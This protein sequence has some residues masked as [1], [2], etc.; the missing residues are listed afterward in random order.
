MAEMSPAAA[1]QATQEVPTIEV[2]DSCMLPDN[3]LVASPPKEPQETLPQPDMEVSPPQDDGMDERLRRMNASLNLSPGKTHDDT[4]LAKVE[5][6]KCGI[7]TSPSEAQH[8]GVLTWWCNH[9]NAAMKHLRSR[10]QW[11]PASFERM[12][13]EEKKSFFL[14]VRQL[15]EEDGELK[16]ARLRDVLVKQMT[17][18]LVKEIMKAKGVKYLPLSVYEQYL[19][20]LLA[21]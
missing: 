2:Q 12:S 14:S 19:G 7:Q 15:K 6:S 8:R 4:A 10:M 3:Q 16:Y 17:T 20:L 1:T 21:L 18:R 5:C 11:P 13:A 9:C